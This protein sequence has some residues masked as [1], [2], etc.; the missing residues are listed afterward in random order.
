MRLNV[1]SRGWRL[2]ISS[3]V[4]AL[5]YAAL[6]YLVL[7]YFLPRF[8]SY[9]G[10]TSSQILPPESYYAAIGI[11]VLEALSAL[12]STTRIRGVFMVALGVL[13]YIFIASTFG[14]GTIRVETSGYSVG[15]D[16]SFILVI[17]ELS[18]LV[19]AARG[20]VAI[21]EDNT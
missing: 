3:M 17:M 1:S 6:S 21:I 13:A 8:L 15:V 18:A 7:L 14:S 2:N 19:E 4:L 16:I 12:F 9:Y 11:V 10:L 20:C 5:V